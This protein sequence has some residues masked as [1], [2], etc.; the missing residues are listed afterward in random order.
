[1]LQN[2]LC[3]TQGPAGS[4]SAASK[5]KECDVIILTPPLKCSTHKILEVHVL[6]GDTEEEGEEEA[7]HATGS[8]AAATADVEASAASAADVEVSAAAA[9]DVVA[10]AAT[11]DVEAFAAAADVEASAATA[12][13]EAFAAAAPAP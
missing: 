11:A 8:P 1:M 5:P 9:A 6:A 4:D 10:F 3:A 7:T 13:M 2:G 12:D